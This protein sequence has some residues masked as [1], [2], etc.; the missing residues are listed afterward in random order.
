MDT[1]FGRDYKLKSKIIIDQIFDSGLSVKEYPFIIKYAITNPPGDKT[2]QI[3]ISAPKRIFKFAV[4]R[5]RLKRLCTE[6]VRSNKNELEAFLKLKNE[7]VG[8]FLIYTGKEELPIVKLEHKIEKLFKK[9][10]IKL[11]ENK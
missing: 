6:A 11:D 10:I 8:I 7:R 2:F 4:H 9:L 1:K 3:V 5:N